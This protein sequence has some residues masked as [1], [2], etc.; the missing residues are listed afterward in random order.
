M[1]DRSLAEGLDQINT[2]ISQFSNSSSSSFDDTI[3]RS[4]AT[5]LST[6]ANEPST[7]MDTYAERRGLAQNQGTAEANRIKSRYDELIQRE[8]SGGAESIS[9]TEEGQ[10]GFAQQTAVLRT[11]AKDTREAIRDLE[12]G[13]E[14]ALLL[15]QSE[16]AQRLDQLIADQ[17]EAVGAARTRYLNLLFNTAGEQRA[18]SGEVRAQNE[19]LRAQNQEIRS[20]LSFETPEQQRAAQF[21]YATKTALQNLAVTA[22][23]AGI[24]ENDSFTDAIGKYRNSRSFLLDQ[25]TAEKNLELIKAQIAK[26]WADVSPGDSN[27]DLITLPDGTTV[28]YNKKD[29]SATDKTRLK[30]ISSAAEV[31]DQIERAYA[32]AVGDEY[33]GFGAGTV[34]RLKGISRT[35]GMWTGTNQDFTSY[36]KL[37]E[38]NLT[39]IAKG[40][41]GESGNTSDQDIARARDSFPSRFNS[42]QEAANAFNALRELLR[43]NVS[44]YGE[45]IIEG[46]Q[47]GQEEQTLDNLFDN[48]LNIITSTPRTL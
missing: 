48:S 13:R 16:T 14:E 4:L 7:I 39:L 1:A 30:T 21:D 26:A 44:G 11:L 29:L 24:T 47:Y 9:R 25:E 15:G 5:E 32:Q 45:V 36:K 17:E 40:I 38:S 12:R 35:A 31:V 10:I 3:N 46:G 22:P 20:A 23:D 34:A 8:T 37:V 43:A 6:A 27:S 2:N 18:Q 41:K 33:G 19:E 28:A 42:P